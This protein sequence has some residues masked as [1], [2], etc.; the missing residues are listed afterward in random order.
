MFRQLFKTIDR[1]F[2]H[3]EEW[4]LF[5]SVLF[6]LLVATVNIILRKMTSDLS[7]Y[8]S[9]EVVQKTIYFSTYIGC[10]AAVRGR[11]LIRIDALPQM[12]PILKKPL[13]L[14][15]HTAVLSFA[16]VMVWFGTQM[17]WDKFHDEY[18]LTETLQIPEFY[19]YAVLPIMGG[20][21][22]LRTLIVLFEDYTGTATITGENDSN[23]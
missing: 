3:I 14:L 9:G 15:S 20:M 10:V 22:F 12:L 1:V 7:L 11:A 16:G 17:A 5:L 13:T 8:W 2:L 4:A 19:F 18:A 6:A 23:V 21:A